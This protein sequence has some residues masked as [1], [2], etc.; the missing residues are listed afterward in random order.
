[1]RPNGAKEWIAYVAEETGSCGD[2]ELCAFDLRFVEDSVATPPQ[3]SG[4]RISSRWR[5]HA[6]FTAPADSYIEVGK[7]EAV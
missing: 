4:I 6:V 3:E 5:A 1:M 7:R 2:D